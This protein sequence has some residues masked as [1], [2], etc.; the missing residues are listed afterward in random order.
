MPRY[1]SNPPTTFRRLLPFIFFIATLP[2]LIATALKNQFFRPRAQDNLPAAFASAVQLNGL[3]AYIQIPPSPILSPQSSTTFELRFKPDRTTFPNQW[4][5]S[6]AS[7][8]KEYY[9]LVINSQLSPAGDTYTINYQFLVSDSKVNCSHLT[10]TY[11]QTIPTSQSDYI[12][13]WHHLAAQIIPNGRLEIYLDG[14]LSTTYVSF[15]SSPCPSDSPLHLGAHTS[16][17]GFF[18]GRIDEIRLSSIARYG[19]SFTPPVVPYTSDV[20]TTALY[21][22]DDNFLDSSPNH[23]DGQPVN[24]VE[25]TSQTTPT[26]T[27]APTSEVVPSPTASP[28]TLTLTPSADSYVDSRFPS[29]NYGPDKKL[30]VDLPAKITYLKFSRPSGLIRSALLRLYV[31]QYSRGSHALKL[32]PDSSWSENSLTYANRPPIAS[33]LIA[34]LTASRNRSWIEI[35][36]DPGL[37][38]SSSVLSLGLEPASPDGL[39][40][41]SK[42]GDQSPQLIISYQPL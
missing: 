7:Q 28:I 6:S 10:T 24:Q 36:I 31:T 33:G 17:S 40:F 21:H 30:S 34:A 19:T 27:V 15:V 18:A 29:A 11:T 1:S 26:P 35:P 4:L 9:G 32:V 22:L 25:F 12:T 8:G 16:S 37:L 23:L 5:I 38:A 2:L 14:T 13:S 42:E 3:D 20:S 41:S 39:Q